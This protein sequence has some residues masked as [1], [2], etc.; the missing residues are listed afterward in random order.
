MDAVSIEGTFRDPVFRARYDV[1]EPIGSG[2]FGR[3]YR[4][5]QRTTGQDVAV[6]VL[7]TLDGGPDDGDSIAR[8]RRELAVCATLHHPNIVRL[9]DSGEGAGNQ[10]FAVFELIPGSTLADV[11]AAENAL[12]PTEAIHLMSQ[13][14]DALAC[15]HA[16]GIVHRD[17]KPANIMVTPTGARRN[18]LVLD[19]G[20]GTYYESVQEGRRRI[21]HRGDFVGTPAYA[22]PEQLRGDGGQ[23]SSD[24]FAWGLVLVECLTGRP[25]L[26]GSAA[27]VIQRQLSPEPIVI[28]DALLR[29]PLGALIASVIDKDPTR[30]P[31]DASALLERL[32]DLAAGGLPERAVLM[33]RDAE[34]PAVAR[35]SARNLSRHWLVPLHR[36]PNFTG[37]EAIL[38]QIRE[39]FRE[40]PLIALRGLGGIGK[41]HLALEYAYRNSYEFDLVAWLR[42]AEPETLA[43]DFAALA[44]CLG[45]SEGDSPEQAAR[46]AA[47]AAWLE[48][49]DRWLLIFDNAPNPAGIRRFL[50]RTYGGQLL[51]TSRHPSWR[52]IGASIEVEEL[53]LDEAA[54]FIL[55]RTGEG[56][57]AVAERLADRLGRLP[58]ALEAAAAYVEATGR[59]LETYVHLLEDQMQVLLDAPS[60]TDQHANVRSTWE[61]SF[62]EVEQ[63]VPAAADLLR[64]LSFLAPEDTP[65]S[66]VTRGSKHLPGELAALASDPVQLDRAIAALRR[67]SLIKVQD[68]AV[69]LHRLVQ[70]ATRSRLDRDSHDEWAGRALRVVEASFPSG[71]AGDYFHPEARRLIPHALTALSRERSLP[72]EWLAAGRLRRRAGLYLSALCLHAQAADHLGRAIALLESGDQPPDNEIANTFADLELVRYALGDLDEATQCGERALEIHERLLGPKDVRVA[73]DLMNLAWV[74]R[75]KGQFERVRTLCERSLEILSTTLG[76]DHPLAAMPLGPLSRAYWGMGDIAGARSA[77]DRALDILERTKAHHPLICACWYSVGQVQFDLGRTEIASR[78][79]ESAIAI[80]EQAY[81]KDH[82][83]VAVSRA[84]RGMIALRRGDLESARSSFSSAI[85]SGERSCH[86]V[87]EDIAIAHCLRARVQR[88]QGNA[89]AAAIGLEQ[90]R[91]ALGLVCGEPTR[92]ASQIELE[93]GL[94]ALDRR[95]YSEAAARGRR[96]IDGLTGYPAQHPYQIPGL[97]LLARA[98][99]AMGDRTAA[100]DVAERAVAIG[101]NAYDCA[102]PDLAAAR[103]TLEGI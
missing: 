9:I 51:V 60:P 58:L 84:V 94:A 23:P 7:H 6:K 46:I 88:L 95:D 90:A 45:L 18:A 29:H 73:V 56:S 65:L 87:H 55:R 79:I 48:Q 83:Q 2:G 34:L 24:L 77:A 100:R 74:L 86:R 19:F 15:A 61:L 28:P 27:Q 96:A 80:G 40:R 82:P 20:L 70:L 35:L 103:I 72:R 36:N 41:T 69:S 57:R 11:I 13:V 38:A 52:S 68:D 26:E 5:R 101:S 43:D 49:H 102:H 37:R 64:L 25:V 92:A 76:M 53:S 67:Y 4:A 3:I 89:D 54:G 85:E 63:E 99:R 71:L 62:R 16:A 93:L 97:D 75:S 78:C 21:T 91:A 59:S 98:L 22:A 33:G 17:L 1:L 39:L 42:A 14:L 8:F 44:R 81:G 31:R 12:A 47:A 66:L 32:V 10:V 50:P 30:R